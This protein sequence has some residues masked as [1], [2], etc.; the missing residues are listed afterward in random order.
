MKLA[1]LY[2]GGKDSTYALLKAKKEN[3]IVCL[4]NVKSKNN[5]S[6]MFQSAANN[7]LEFQSSALEIPLL[8][9]E[10]LG[11]KELELEDLKKL[12]EEAKERYKIEGLV[13]GT[14]KSVYQSS[15][16]QK[17]CNDLDL[18][19]FNPLWQI[20]EEE[21]LEE[22]FENNF[23]VIIVGIAA[24]P[25]TKDFL[26][27]K[28]DRKLAN[29]LKELNVSQIGEGGEFESFVIN[30]PVHKR[31]LEIIDSDNNMTGENSGELVIKEVKL[32]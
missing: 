31:K 24:Y 5:E 21:Y 16:I 10:T 9:K 14:I 19:C 28:L 30:S 1:V 20:D 4:L 11:E 2:S 25:L 7:I 3:E 26:G 13:T 6:Y 23:E 29:K 18:W 27:K 12:I 22:L 32:K 15:R 17:I 8:Q